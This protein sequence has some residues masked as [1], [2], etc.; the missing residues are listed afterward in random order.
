MGMYVKILLGLCLAL[1]AP[2][3]S[4]ST[5]TLERFS[6]SAFTTSA[7]SFFNAGVIHPALLY[8]CISAVSIL[9]LTLLKTF[10]YPYCPSTIPLVA[11]ALPYLGHAL[12]FAREVPWVLML[13]WHR[14]FGRTYAFVLFSRLCVSTSSLSA[15]RTI[16]HTEHS[17]FGKDI[18]FTY[19]PFMPILGKG[20]VTSSGKAWR[21]KRTRVSKIFRIDLLDK[22][23]DITL[24]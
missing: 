18:P 16:L 10:L 4:F 5:K 17:K 8:G 2:S 19:A 21:T 6:A 3:L 13:R 9:C 22:V 15:L 24:R 7:T 14:K 11:G 23:P 1:I 12:Y 20:I